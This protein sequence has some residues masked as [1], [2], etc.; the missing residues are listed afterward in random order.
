MSKGPF[1]PVYRSLLHHPRFRPLSSDARSLWLALKLR[2]GPAGIDRVYREELVE[3]TGLDD[4][5]VTAA[6]EELVRHRWIET[7][8]GLFWLV[9]GFANEPM[10]QSP[11][12]VESVRIHIGGLRG[13]IVDR[14]RERY[15]LKGTHE[16]S[17][18]GKGRGSANPSA[19]GTPN[20]THAPTHEATHGPTHART[21]VLSSSLSSSSS[22]I[23][24]S[25]NNHTQCGLKPCVCGRC[26]KPP[27]PG[28][29][30]K[31]QMREELA[32]S[33]PGVAAKMSP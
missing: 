3:V 12:A 26:G 23:R 29:M 22:G 25:N 13:A 6:I 18:M 32:K 27:G 30:S 14:Y 33:A 1:R 5:G 8:E 9:E 10:M 15:D 21:P 20:P 31:R 11:N 17:P 16:G 7:G 4:A 24:S 28:Q 2:L 19:M